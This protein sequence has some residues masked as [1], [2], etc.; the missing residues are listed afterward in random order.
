MTDTYIEEP[1]VCGYRALHKRKI[2]K[3]IHY[4]LVL[5]IAGYPLLRL[6]GTRELLSA[7]YD[8][9]IGMRWS[10]FS[11]SSP[12]T[13]STAL[14]DAS[15]KCRRVHRDVT[16]GNIILFQHRI[17]RSNPNRKHQLSRTGYMVDW[18]LSR[19][20]EAGSTAPRD[21]F[22]YSVLIWPLTAAVLLSNSI[23]RRHGSSWPVCYAF[24]TAM[25]R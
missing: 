15:E 2:I 3:R 4:R 25:I 6:K 23:F 9:F 18:D 13:A 19:A 17:D 8:A 7:T 14:R 10:S 20:A 24:A 22:D 5:D 12:L 1:W 16:P 11:G 21:E